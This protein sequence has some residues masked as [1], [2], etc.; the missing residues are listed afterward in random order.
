MP[1]YNQPRVSGAVFESRHPTGP[2]FSGFIEIDGVKTFICLWDKVS[3]KGNDYLQISE[4]KKKIAQ[5][6][7]SGA[8]RQKQL[9]QRQAPQQP[10]RQQGFQ[11]RQPPQRQVPRQPT[12]QHDDM[13]DDIPF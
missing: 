7:I 12:Q 11:Q 8:P 3:A 4:D 1:G 2:K 9:P 10:L 13:D 5:N 6:D